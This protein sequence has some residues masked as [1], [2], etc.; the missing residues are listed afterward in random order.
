[1]S[2]NNSTQNTISPVLRDQANMYDNAIE[3]LT[4]LADSLISNE[5]EIELTLKNSAGEPTK[6]SI[7]SLFNFDSE[8]KRLS[9][10]VDSLSGTGSSAYVRQSDGSYKRIITSKR[11]AAPGRITGMPIPTEFNRKN[12]WFFENFLSPLLYISFDLSNMVEPGVNRVAV[13]RMILDLDTEEKEELFNSELSGRNDLDFENTVIFLNSRGISYFIDDD[14]YDIPAPK[15]RYEGGFGVVSYYDESTATGTLRHYKLSNIR[16]TDR[17]D[18]FTNSKELKSGDKL[19]LDD[20]SRFE[21]TFIDTSTRYVNL[22]R[23]S[24]KSAIKIGDNVLLLETEERTSKQLN[25][26]IGYGEKQILFVSPIDTEKNIASSKYSNGVCF[27]SNLL[28]FKGADSEEM[29]LAEYYSKEVTDFGMM[30]M[31]L[32]KERNIPTI[33]GRIPNAPSISSE[34]FKVVQ[35]NDHIRQEDLTNNIKSKI[36]TKTKLKSDLKK[37]DSELADIGSRI[38]QV[39][40]DSTEYSELESQT[41]IKIE[42]KTVKIRE[43]DSLTT[44]LAL[45]YRNNPIDIIRPKRRVRG[46]WKIPDP[47]T[48]DR[49]GKQEV[50]GFNIRYRYLSKEGSGKNPLRLDYPSSGD[51]IEEGLFSNW[52]LIKTK[53]RTKVYDDD[54]GTFRWDDE[55]TSNPDAVNS[56]QLDIPISPGESVEIAIQSISEAGYPS[57]PLVSEFSNIVKI[58]YPEELTDDIDLYRIL[59]EA[60][61][62]E[63]R[64]LIY[65]QIESYGLDRH[66]RDTRTV[67]NRYFAH[68]ANDLSSGFNDTQGSVL[69]VYDVIKDLR[70]EL[71]DLKLQIGNRTNVSV[72]TSNGTASS[73]KLTV[74]IEGK[75]RFGNRVRYDVNNQSIVDLTPPSYF[76]VVKN[77]E[78]NQR[79]GA[80]VKET[81]DLVLMNTGSGV[82]RLSSQYPG[83][84]YEELPEINGTNLTWRGTSFADDFYRTNLRYSAV[85]VRYSSF[86]EWESVANFRSMFGFG[87]QQSKQTCGQFIYSRYKDITGTRD[88]YGPGS[89]IQPDYLKTSS[90]TSVQRNY[91]WNG[92]YNNPLNNSGVVNQYSLQPTGNGALSNFSIHVDHPDVMEKKISSSQINPEKSLSIM[93]TMEHSS[94]VN[95]EKSN[96]GFDI[97]QEVYR[98][99][100]GKFLKFGFREEDRFLIGD[101]TTGMYLYMNPRKPEDIQVNGVGSKSFIE[102]NAG[103]RITVPIVVEYRMTDYMDESDIYRANNGNNPNSLNTNPIRTQYLGVV[104]GYSSKNISRK[105]I[106]IEYEKTIGLDIYRE[107]KTAF[108]FDVRVNAVF[109]SSKNTITINGLTDSNDRDTIDRTDLINRGGDATVVVV[110][111]ST[112]ST[113]TL[114]NKI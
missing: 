41:S 84:T 77:R 2:N 44:D 68:N 63:E 69:S 102:I 11:T 38:Q 83:S 114:T 74:F 88:L 55:D 58:D 15:L 30:I 75:D 81:Y 48:D 110:D 61:R 94:Y 4:K 25:I 54:S 9:D 59:E 66:F 35:I 60:A 32:S 91:V 109:G 70:K 80:I 33:L 92:S 10:A 26:N 18:S 46:F 62:E 90:S 47:K 6:I 106:N 103:E 57:N 111:S 17:T 87:Q 71:S 72:D 99:D 28:I 86:S 89:K 52:N 45:I 100:A 95:I 34:N 73:G 29:T 96:R 3:V 24:G 40:R 93:N 23:L 85:P 27:D 8:I 14:Y 79:R 67:D 21:I 43:L 16:Y 53:T 112:L 56:N 12:N 19:L 113:N 82:L 97:Q 105:D 5:T 22:K 76:S 13:K 50:I 64:A 49:T 36:A 20:G 1:M 39:R 104:G 108:S 42:E 107:D 7:P 78:E 51:T 37:I 65:R 101:S 31:G 98:N